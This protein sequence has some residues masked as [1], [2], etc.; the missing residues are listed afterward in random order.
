MALR[1]L[2]CFVLGDDDYF[3]VDIGNQTFVNNVA[4]SFDDFT[5]GHLKKLIWEQKKDD[6]VDF[7]KLN[8]WKVEIPTDK[9]KILEVL[10]SLTELDIKREYGG[11]KLS[12]PDDDIKD[13][14]PSQPPKRHIHI[15]VQPLATTAGGSGTGKSRFLDEIENLLKE[16]AE[17]CNDEEI[18]NAFANMIVI[19]TTYGN[20]STADNI[21]QRIGPQ[22]SLA[23]RILFEYFRPQHN[24][25]EFDFPSF[26]AY[27]NQSDISDFALNIALRVIYID[28][29]E[30]KQATISHPLLVVVVGI[31]E[32][33]KLHDIDKQTSKSL[34]NTIGSSMC[35]APAD[36]FF[37]P[38]LA[39]TIEGPIEEYITGSMHQPLHLPLHLLEEHHA[40]KIGKAMNLFNDDYVTYSLYFQHSIS[41]HGGHV[42]ALEYFYDFFSQELRK[43]QDPDK[44][45]IEKVMERVKDSI[46]EKYCFD[47]F[48]N[49]TEPLIKAILGLPVN[50]HDKTTLD[51]ESKISYQKLSSRGIVNLIKKDTSSKYYLQL[52]YYYVWVSALVEVQASKHPG[53]KYWK[54]MLNYDEPMYW[55]N[56][57]DFN[58]KFWDN[59]VFKGAKFSSE[60]PDVEVVLPED[61]KL[62]KLQQHKQ[63]PVTPTNQ[64][65]EVKYDGNMEVTHGYITFDY[66]KND[67]IKK[68]MGHIFLNAPGADP[69]MSLDF[70]I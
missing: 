18:R 45:K 23:I 53:M 34:I 56:F 35:R 70:L 2:S 13:H 38:I 48:S 16:C 7:G 39:G 61:I 10:K 69:L 49:L 60:F 32:F 64:N 24:F 58:A 27:C 62:Y 36:I 12:T 37:I 11:V 46:Q 51:D 31:D 30:A 15:I 21:D 42:K 22:A 26:R 3:P 1:I 50:K 41:D 65:K 4:I 59:I 40:I 5:V 25:S 67:Y 28:K 14:F 19:N 33:N 20:G 54:V 57:E 68:Y 43:C 6:L 29:M 66:L 52:L 47:S 44:V 9:P 17:K 63:Y 8:L 55:Q